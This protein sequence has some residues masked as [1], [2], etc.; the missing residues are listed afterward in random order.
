[1]TGHDRK[2]ELPSDLDWQGLADPAATTIVYMPV[3]TLVEMSARLIANGLPPST[4]AAAVARATR[5]DEQTV[6]ATIGDLHTKRAATPLHG[7]VL[8][9]IGRVLS[10]RIEAEASDPVA[11]RALGRRQ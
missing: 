9:L 8:V 2:G 10:N 5:H 11:Q 4:P 7:P 3:K 6:L 1:V